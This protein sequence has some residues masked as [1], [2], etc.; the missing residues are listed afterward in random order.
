MQGYCYKRLYIN[1]HL[2]E[3]TPLHKEQLGRLPNIWSTSHDQSWYQMK[4]DNVSKCIIVVI[5]L[6]SLYQSKPQVKKSLIED[7]GVSSCYSGQTLSQFLQGSVESRQQTNTEQ[8]GVIVDVSMFGAPRHHSA[9]MW[10][11]D[12]ATRML[13]ISL[14]SAPLHTEMV[15]N[16]PQYISPTYQSKQGRIESLWQ[17]DSRFHPTCLLPICRV[18]SRRWSTQRPRGYYVRLGY[19]CFMFPSAVHKVRNLP[20]SR[21][22]L[23]P[24][25]HD[26][27]PFVYFDDTSATYGKPTRTSGLAR[28]MPRKQEDGIVG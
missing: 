8:G 23:M 18:H 12:H 25:A 19:W 5:W 1:F 6:R 24:G 16:A 28:F 3:K 17:L 2:V 10:S 21:M 7:S 11:P 20:T 4:I 9:K 13:Y 26:F 14:N 27:V 15:L 22:W